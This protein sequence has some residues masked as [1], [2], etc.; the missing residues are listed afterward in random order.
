MLEPRRA[1]SDTI[2]SRTP[3]EP[4]GAR[5]RDGAFLVRLD[6]GRDRDEPVTMWLKSV[7]PLRWSDRPQ[8][9]RFQTKGDAH[10]AAEAAKAVGWTLEDAD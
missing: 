9:M 10:R 2:G 8:A 4:H 7:S 1:K 5:G 6:R 3:S